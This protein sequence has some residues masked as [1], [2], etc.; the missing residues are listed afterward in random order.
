MTQE[1]AFARCMWCLQ[2]IAVMDGKVE[3]HLTL[4]IIQA[5]GYGRCP[6]SG[7]E[8]GITVRRGW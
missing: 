4:H 3:N 5:N 6:G 1:V 7:R 8:A 2:D